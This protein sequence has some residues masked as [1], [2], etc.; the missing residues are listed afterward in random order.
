MAFLGP[1]PP[2]VGD[3]SQNLILFPTYTHF[4]GGV[5]Y[6]LWPLDATPSSPLK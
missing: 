3:G 2:V 1:I 6:G 5:H 4:S